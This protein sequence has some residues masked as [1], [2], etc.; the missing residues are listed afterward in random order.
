MSAFHATPCS[1]IRPE[2]V[3]WLW[4]PY[5]AR[6]KLAL[7]DG[8]PDA[9]KTFLALDLAARLSRGGPW[10][11]GQPL[12]RPGTTLF[13]SAE[14]NAADTVCP[15]VEAAGADL[16]RII[17]APDRGEP[18]LMIPDDLPAL[19]ELVRR[20]A[21]DLVVFDTL[22]PFLAPTVSTN[23]ELSVRR[24]LKTLADLADRCGFLGLL[25]RHLNKYGGA[26]S[27]YRGLGTIGLCG[28]VRTG[29][30]LA[31]HPDDPELRVMAHPK[32]NPGPKGPSLGFRLAHNDH[33]RPVLR[34]TGRVDLSADELCATAEPVGKRPRERAAE[35]LRAELANGP[36]KASELIA[37][38]AKVGIAE[39]TLDR[40]KKDLGI[41]SER[42]QNGDKGEWVWSDPT[43]RGS[44]GVLEDLPPL[45][46]LGLDGCGSVEDLL[47]RLRGMA[48]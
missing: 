16:A 34:W 41:K 43:V 6:G 4:E 20:H 8:D 25:I 47:A 24:A 1:A 14:D 13:L 33:G 35:W 23:S 7:L 32:S 22:S 37:A 2:P 17:V 11:D 45:P 5:L 9:G 46:D 28:S 38:A 18:L 30:L 31:R 44:P 10:P 39:R 21:A 3:A 26:K 48:Y 40:V 15:R 19:E 12:P 42:V 29:L 27:L 36:R